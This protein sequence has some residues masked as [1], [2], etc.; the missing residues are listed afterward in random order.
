MESTWGVWYLK[1]T[2]F[3]PGWNLYKFRQ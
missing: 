3:F 1:H 2:F